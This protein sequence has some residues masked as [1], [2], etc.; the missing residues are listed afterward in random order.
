MGGG[1]GGGRAGGR[2]GHVIRR[3]EGW[4]AGG[5]VVV[6]AHVTPPPPWLTPHWPKAHGRRP[7]ISSST[8]AHGE[9]EGSVCSCIELAPKGPPPPPL[10]PLLSSS[11]S[12]I[13]QVTS[14]DQGHQHYQ[15]ISRNAREMDP[16]APTGETLSWLA[17]TPATT[18]SASDAALG[19]SG[20][21]GNAPARPV[22]AAVRMVEPRPFARRLHRSPGPTADIRQ[23]ALRTNRHEENP[24]SPNRDHHLP[25]ELDPVRSETPQ[26]KVKES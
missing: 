1:G 16:Q 19:A 10:T 23:R 2:N 12:A 25:A 18:T 20:A 11:G 9:I 22:A 13:Q 26:G 5:R 4:R 14:R 3:V 15:V 8:S 7:N 24:W 6:Y 17:T 21:G